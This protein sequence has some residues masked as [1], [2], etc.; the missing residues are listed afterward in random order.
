MTLA[1]A[2]QRTSD[3]RIT[4]VRLAVNRALGQQGTRSWEL[5]PRELS[6][7][8]LSEPFH[9]TVIHEEIVLLAATFHPTVNQDVTWTKRQPAALHLTGRFSWA[10]GCFTWVM[11]RNRS[12]SLPF[13][14]SIKKW[15]EQTSAC[16]FTRL[17]IKKWHE[18]NVSL[19]PCTRREDFHE[20]LAVSPE[21]WSVTE[22]SACCFTRLS[23]KKWHDLNVSLPCTRRSRRFS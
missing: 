14:P 19:L 10:V 20:L 22:V 13:H 16:R 9:Q 8:I 5:Q 3:C 1:R 12:V 15:H 7:T 23:I 11:K 18:Q 2:L 17:S 4:S 6:W 21:S